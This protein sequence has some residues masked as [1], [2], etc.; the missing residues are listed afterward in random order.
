MATI[1]IKQV[2]SAIKR[3]ARQKAT[4]KALGFR[5]LNQVIEKEATPQIL[6]MIKKVAHMV[7]VVE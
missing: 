3:P 2:R 7:E 1:K 6:G 5:R 4:I